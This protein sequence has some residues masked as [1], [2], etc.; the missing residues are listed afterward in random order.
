MNRFLYWVTSVCFVSLFVPTSGTGAE[1]ETTAGDRVFATG[2][3]QKFH[4]K[5]SDRQFSALTPAGGGRPG[6]P[7]FGPMGFGPPTPAPEGTHR[8]TF[9]VNF[10]WAHGDLV[11]DNETFCDVADRPQSPCQ[12]AEARRLGDAELQQRRERPDPDP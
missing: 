2:G 8:N 5:L 3:I 10:P 6:G 1:K 7:G 4:L 9:G 12:R 11:I